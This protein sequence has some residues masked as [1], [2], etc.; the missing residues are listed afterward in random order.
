MLMLKDESSN[1]K[2][3]VSIGW[4]DVVHPGHIEL[5]RHAKGICDVVICLVLEA[6]G[7]DFKEEGRVRSQYLSFIP[8]IDEV[9][10]VRRDQIEQKIEEISPTFLFTGSKTSL[11]TYNFLFDMEKKIKTL[12]GTVVI[13]GGSSQADGIN[14]HQ[15][16][17]RK[18]KSLEQIGV[19]TKDR[20]ELENFSDRL[21]DSVGLLDSARILV[22]GDLIVDRYIATDPLGMSS[23]APVLVVEEVNTEDFVGGA[24]I[25]ASHIA[26]WGA[27][28]SLIS[29]VGLDAEADYAEE[30]LDGYGVKT[31]LIKVPFRKTN[32]KTRYLAGNQKLFRVS[33]LGDDEIDDQSEQTVLDLIDSLAA[34]IDAIIVCDFVYGNIKPRILDKCRSL[35]SNYGVRLLGDIQCSSQIGTNVQQFHGFDAVTPTEKELRTSLSDPYSSI[36]ELS[37]KLLNSIDLGLLV[38]KLG[39]KGFIIFDRTTK[40]VKRYYFP[41]LNLNPV[42]TSGAGDCLLATCAISLAVGLRPKLVGMIGA[43]TAAKFVGFLGNTP[44]PKADILESLSRYLNEK[45]EK[46]FD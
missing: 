15:P 25:V 35:K 38:V 17:P 43:I 2:V 30:K 27:D 31:H 40:P 16:R 8:F 23:E 22:I 37:K 4:F 6:E 1:R 24:G 10:I 36:E 28:V 11:Q 34:S 32:L 13:H 18:S 20:I 41:A 39:S 9:Q 14:S 45:S 29:V 5:F 44:L 46:N 26:A 12:G 42:D 21:V 19:E 33:R 7:F 3:G